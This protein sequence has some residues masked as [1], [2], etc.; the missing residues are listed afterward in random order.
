MKVAYNKEHLSAVSMWQQEEAQDC[1]VGNL[2]IERL[3]V[4]LEKRGINL[5]VV[6]TPETRSVQR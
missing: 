2:V 4:K 3:S 6:A 1:C 5:D